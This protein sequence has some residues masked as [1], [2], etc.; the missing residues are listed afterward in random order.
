MK[1]FFRRFMS[2]F[3][4]L[5]FSMFIT[6]LMAI[7]ITIILASCSNSG[8]DNGSSS[9]SSFWNDDSLIHLDSSRIIIHPDSVGY[10]DSV[11]Y[12]A[13]SSVGIRLSGW[14]EG[15]TA[16][17]ATNKLD[18]TSIPLSGDE[19]RAGVKSFPADLKFGD[20]PRVV[21][22]IGFMRRHGVMTNYYFDGVDTFWAGNNDSI[23][24]RH[25]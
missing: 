1:H 7:V 6:L 18:P 22:E 23:W 19:I 16:F 15:R 21:E 14:P 10:T 24:T 4:G 17:Q 5:D 11:Y 2:G 20:V 13:D 3:Y 9:D 25:D 12:N 8:P